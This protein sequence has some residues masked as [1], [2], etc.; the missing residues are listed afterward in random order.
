MNRYEE[1][2]EMFA[3]F[4]LYPR[5]LTSLAIK[6][7][8]RCGLTDRDIYNV[9]YDMLSGL[10]FR[11]SIE[12]QERREIDQ[13]YRIMRKIEKQQ[14]AHNTDCLVNATRLWNAIDGMMD[15]EYYWSLMMIYLPWAFR[16][17]GVVNS[18]RF[19]YR[20]S[21]GGLRMFQGGEV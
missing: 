9:G 10:P 6:F 4:G 20:K 16:E 2:C 15:P 7:C 5:P 8:I 19:T 13:V 11:E 3:E 17:P 18:M 14:S 12:M 1:V 21:N